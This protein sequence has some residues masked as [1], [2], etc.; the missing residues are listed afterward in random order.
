MWLPSL[1]LLLLLCGSS[2]AALM[3]A[4]CH[5]YVLLM[6]GFEMLLSMCTVLVITFSA[7]KGTR[8]SYMPLV[9]FSDGDVGTTVSVSPP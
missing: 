6:Y 2:N 5:A 8:Q 9:W 7:L 3:L 1:L 4:A